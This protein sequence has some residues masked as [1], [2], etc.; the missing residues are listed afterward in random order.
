[1]KLL[2]AKNSGNIGVGIL[3]IKFNKLGCTLTE[4]DAADDVGIDGFTE[5]FDF[6]TRESL[7][8][9][10]A[11][12]SKC[13]QEL[14]VN[15]LSSFRFAVDNKHLDYWQ[16]LNIPVAIC[17]TNENFLDKTF[18]VLGKDIAIK[19]TLTEKTR[20]FGSQL[21]EIDA[22]AIKTFATLAKSPQEFISTIPQ[23]I[24]AL[25]G[26]LDNFDPY[27]RPIINF[28]KDGHQHIMFAPKT[29]DAYQKSPQ[30]FNLT[31]D[32]S[33]EE[34]R[35]KVQNFQERGGTIELPTDYI[36]INTMPSMIEKFRGTKENPGG[37][38]IFQSAHKINDKHYFHL[39]L[40]N[41]NTGKK[42]VIPIEF[43]IIRQGSKEFT[44][45]NYA[46]R[47]AYI[48]ELS[49]PL[50]ATL[51]ITLNIQF[52]P[53]GHKAFEVNEA[54]RTMRSFAACNELILYDRSHMVSV[55]KLGYVIDKSF[56]SMLDHEDAV[57]ACMRIIE[58]TLH[59][60]L[61]FPESQFSD[62]DLKTL[63]DVYKTFKTG[64]QD[65]ESKEFKMI[66]AKNQVKELVSW[67]KAG[68]GF[69][70]LRPLDPNDWKFNLFGKN[71]SVRIK[72]VLEY[73]ELAKIDYGMAMNAESDGDV[74]F[75]PVEE[76]EGTRIM[77]VFPQWLSQKDK[78]IL[79]RI[80]KELQPH[81][82]ELLPKQD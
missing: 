82:R 3:K 73:V 27:F 76:L 47:K 63:Q 58:K 81:R 16:R 67:S 18:Y 75:L 36:K 13:T 54:L 64:I 56:I 32:L 37:A 78:K 41:L 40:K 53:W 77:N 28:D 23:L 59:T 30:E 48:L 15:N 35:K 49:I 61:H 9:I 1:M 5:L 51:P 79:K 6:L 10:I 22:E 42:G 14:D 33:R 11:I 62:E 2:R 65:I 80:R 70:S 26:Q 21:R 68:N 60:T 25:S 43:H 71:F 57:C 38:F 12:Q 34:L 66:A 7:A 17:F 50:E 19:G 45:S 44:F 20:I 24:D 52:K 69:R 39:K 46:E 8:K 31:L 29:P 55:L 74:F 4:T 72:E